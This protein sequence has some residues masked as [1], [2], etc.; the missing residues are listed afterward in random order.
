[1]SGDNKTSVIHYLYCDAGNYKFWSKFAVSGVAKREEIQEHLFDG[2][3]FIPK[4][5]GVPKL[6]PAI[7]NENDHELHLINEIEIVESTATP[8][9]MSYSE[10]LKRLKEA[11]DA[12]WF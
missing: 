11:N 5:I 2:E 10:L 8:V 3:F 9:L 12:G 4:R 7:T 6:V 1:M